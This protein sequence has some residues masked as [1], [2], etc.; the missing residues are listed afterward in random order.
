ML[1]KYITEAQKNKTEYSLGSTQIII[2]EQPNIDFGQVVQQ[3]QQHV[4]HYLLSLIDT[5]YVGQFE[6]LSLKAVDS[7]YM[8]GAIY[9]LPVQ[10][11]IE[12]AFNDIVHEMAHAF[13][14]AHSQDV[15]GDQEVAT[16]FIYKRQALKALLDN[17]DYDFNNID[18]DLELDDYLFTEVGYPMLQKL[19]MSLFLDPYS[20]TS[21]REYFATAFEGYFLYRNRKE[22]KELCPAVY[23]KLENIEEIIL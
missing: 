16:E 21:L 2:L 23:E 7:A 22:I 17:P 1:R 3:L 20:I 9:M 13:E 6:E 14:E 10:T 12:D 4:P 5:I 18:Y 11:S 8:D 19:T 15:Y